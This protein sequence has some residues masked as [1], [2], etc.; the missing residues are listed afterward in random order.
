[1]TNMNIFIYDY[2]TNTVEDASIDEVNELINNGEAIELWPK[3]TRAEYYSLD[4]NKHH[5][6]RLS[7]ENIMNCDVVIHVD[8]LMDIYIKG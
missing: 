5:D 4:V 2:N 1:M 8:S 6:E 7:P 3:Q